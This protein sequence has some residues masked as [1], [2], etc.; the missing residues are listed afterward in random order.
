MPA[1][2]PDTGLTPRQ[3]AFATGIASGLSQADAYRAAYPRSAK[4]QEKSVWERAS[5]LA[6]NAKVSARVAFLGA[7][8]AAANDVTVERVV[9][10]L[11]RI[12]FGDRRDLM[13]WGPD[14]VRLKDSG[15]LTHDQAAAVAEV[16]E[17]TNLHGG[18]IKIKTHDKVKALELLGRHLGVFAED[19]KQANPTGF[20]PVKFFADLFRKPEAG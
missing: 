19:N 3:E 20:D 17:T 4:W 18:S 13:E 15:E 6:A 8:A 14:G 10:E 9:R 1:K 7:K 5:A 16:S 11:A 12:A 2:N